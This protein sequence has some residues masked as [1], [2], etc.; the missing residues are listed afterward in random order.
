MAETHFRQ[1]ETSGECLSRL[2]DTF[3]SFVV[4]RWT[5]YCVMDDMKTTF[6]EE[7]WWNAEMVLSFD[8]C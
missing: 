2:N 1:E 5:N 4:F 6:V 3:H 7:L 8:N